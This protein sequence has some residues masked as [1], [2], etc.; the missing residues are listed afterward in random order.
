MVESTM[1]IFDVFDID[2]QKRKADHIE[3][4]GAADETNNIHPNIIDHLMVMGSAKK[5]KED[6]PNTDANS[7]NVNAS[8]VNGVAEYDEDVKQFMPRLT[9]DEV[10]P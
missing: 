1:D 6:A 8:T 5:F 2:S 10:E 4:N 7:E 3:S 9:L